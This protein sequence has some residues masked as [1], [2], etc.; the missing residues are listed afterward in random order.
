[1]L[2]KLH[3]LKEFFKKIVI[4]KAV[5]NEVVVI[6]KKKKHIDATLVEK[7]IIIFLK[8]F[9]IHYTNGVI[10]VHKYKT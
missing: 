4:P 6:G 9:I 3:L 7:A 8:F 1:K 10:Q 5:Y 2:I